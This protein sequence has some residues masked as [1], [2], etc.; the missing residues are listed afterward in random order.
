MAKQF[1]GEM[2]LSR[3][4][5]TEEQL[6]IALREQQTTFRKIGEILVGL[7]FLTTEAMLKTLGDQLGI[8]YMLFS[9][10]PKIIPQDNYPSLKFMKQYKAL[11]I[12]KNGSSVQVAM[13]DPLDAYARDALRLFFKCDVEVFLSSEKDVMEGIEQLFGNSVQ[14]SSIMEGMIGEDIDLAD[15]GSEEDIHHLRN[16]ALEGPIVKLVNMIITR[17]IEDRASD[18]HIEAFENKVNVRYRIDGVLCEAE[19]LPKRLQSAVISRAKIMAKLNIAERRLPQDGRIKLRAAGREI[20]LR[21]STI[22]TIHGESIVMRILDRGGS[23]ISLE[24]LGFN[25]TSLEN[26]KKI[27]SIPYGMVLVTGPT[28]SGKTTTLYAALSR[29]NHFN[30]KIITIEDPA[31]YEIEGINQIQVKPKIGL[32]FSSGLRHIVRQDPDIIMIGEIRDK[33]TAEIAIQSALTGHLVFSTLHT[34]DAP[35]AVTRL[36]DMG[37]ESFLVSSALVGVLAQRLVRIICPHCKQLTEKKLETVD[38]NNNHTHFESYSGI[39]CNECRFTGYMGRTSISELMVIDD[40]IRK[41]ILERT[42]ADVIRKKALSNGMQTLRECGMQKAKRG[43]TTIDEVLRV[44]QEEV[45]GD[46]LL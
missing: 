45:C 33:E 42:S 46:I 31:E 8:R 25:E 37:V 14:M 30:R 5:I 13:A 7:G 39:G 26:I 4:I 38:S 36:L 11:P 20:D 32:T 29:I 10:F 35:G 23:V 17:G 15:I 16:M 21:I 12:G 9:E 18:I 41:L 6:G 28:G 1:F 24:E 43:I 44:T 2:L 40:D 22:P 27:I 34:N 19:S 3:A